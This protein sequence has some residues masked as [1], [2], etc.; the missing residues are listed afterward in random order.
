ME[1]GLGHRQVAALT[2]ELVHHVDAG[3]AHVVPHEGGKRQVEALEDLVRCVVPDE[4]RSVVVSNVDRTEL[5]GE[6]IA[7]GVKGVD[8]IDEGVH[9]VVGH[10][11]VEDVAAVP[12]AVHTLGLHRHVDRVVPGADELVDDPHV[13]DA[14]VVGDLALQVEGIPGGGR[15]VGQVLRRGPVVVEDGNGEG[16]SGVQVPEGIFDQ[17]LVLQVP[18]VYLRDVGPEPVEPIAILV[19]VQGVHVQHPG[20]HTTLPELDAHHLHADVVGDVDDEGEGIAR[21]GLGV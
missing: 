15:V 2:I 6:P 18:V 5:G 7:R 12:P 13:G 11:E 14:Y 4:D 10:D 17:E 16:P 19:H 3:E 1:S 20:G 8:G 9:P 21:G